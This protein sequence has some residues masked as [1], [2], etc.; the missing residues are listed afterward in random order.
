MATT[1][2]ARVAGL[3]LLTAALGLG[4]V[5]SAP[6]GTHIGGMWPVGLVSGVLVYAGRRAAPYLAGAFLVLAL[7]TFVLGGYSLGVSGG[8]AVAIVVEGL[9]T[10]QVL[11]VRWGYGRRL[12][13]DLDLAR[14]TLAALV[15]AATGGVLFA[16][17][18]GIAGFGVPWEVLAM[19]FGSHLASQLIVLSLFMEEFRHPGESGRAETWLR[20]AFT[21]V[22]TLGAFISV[23][24]PGMVFFVLPLIAWGALRAPM[25]EA[26]WQLV[27]VAT[28]ASTLIQLDRGPFRDLDVLQQRSPELQ[29]GPQI[30]FLLGCALV[31]LPFATV[32]ARSRQSAAEVV[33]ERERLS[34]IV[35]GATGMAIIETDEHGLIT[36]FNPGAEALLGWTEEELLGRRADMFHSEEEIAKQA[37][38]LGVPATLRDVALHSAQPEI[39]PRDWRYIRKDGQ[40]RTMSMVLAK[41]TD[42]GGT[43]VGYLSTAEDITE[44]VRA[45][46]ALEGALQTERRA[47]A[48]LTEIDRTKDAFVSSVSHE[49]RTP[50]TNIV[51]YLE[52]LL[53]GAYGETSDAQHEALGRIDS[54]SHRLLELI[55]NLLTLSSLESLDVQMI[56]QPVDLREVIRRSGERVHLDATERGQRL[57]VD[58]PIEPVVVLGDEEHLE[59]MVSNLATN[60]VKFTPDGGHITL[61]VRAEGPRASIEV[62]D[63]GVGFPEEERS[64]LFNRFYRTTHAQTEAVSGSGLG[65]SIAR[66]IAQLHG[67]RISARSNPGEGSTFTVQFDEEGY[68]ALASL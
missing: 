67:A 47:V 58:L 50:I 55:D 27:V 25:R 8:Y 11:T 63:T 31:C 23:N 13:D 49:L 22:V 46:S 41:M 7:A 42:K 53:D 33:S 20:W 21:V 9:V 51:G 3:M 62:Q 61:R 4:A 19:A 24:A 43:A 34:R 18:A 39:G 16:L 68:G 32:V 26:L 28:L 30:A 10:V 56:K 60:A 14:F 12:N 37:A 54:N 35:S 57:D 15:G 2:R 65:L 36:L 45:Q 38:D 66:S 40:V 52:L 64:L 5:L 48:H 44:R 59:R 6:A 17:T 29:S 1:P